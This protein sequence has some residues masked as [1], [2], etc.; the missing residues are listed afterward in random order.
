MSHPK[1]LNLDLFGEVIRPEP[2][3]TPVEV[4]PKDTVTVYHS[5]SRLIPPHLREHPLLGMLES[6]GNPFSS[7]GHP[8]VIHAGSRQSAYERSRRGAVH[9]YEIPKSLLSETRRDSDDPRDPEGTRPFNMNTHPG[10]QE[11]PPQQELWEYQDKDVNEV[12]SGNSVVPY[13]NQ[14][15]DKGS[16]SYMFPKH[17]VHQGKITYKGMMDGRH[18]NPPLQN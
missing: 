12:A 7:N 14:F 15:E 8:D 17:L 13:F 10:H 18:L 5:S 2:E 1:H 4:K 16:T 11:G 3:A 9:V 6:G